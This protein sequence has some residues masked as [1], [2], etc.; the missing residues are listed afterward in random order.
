LDYWHNEGHT[1]LT[2]QQLSYITGIPGKRLFRKLKADPHTRWQICK[3]ICAPIA[4]WSG[5]VGFTLD[6]ADVLAKILLERYPTPKYKSI[7]NWTGSING[8]VGMDGWLEDLKE[9]GGR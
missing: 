5:E 7:A 9:V 4:G 3:D 8:E 1:G 2:I 6:N